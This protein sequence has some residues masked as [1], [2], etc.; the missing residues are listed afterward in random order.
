MTEANRYDIAIIGGGLAG[1]S[2][3][4]ALQ[5][6]GLKMAVIEA[7]SFD[8]KDSPSFDARSVAL[9]YGSKQIFSALGLWPDIQA[10]GVTPIERIHIS[11]R[12]HSGL[13]RLDCRDEKLEALGYVVDIRILGQVL[14]NNMLACREADYLCPA[15]LQSVEFKPD[16]AAVHYEQ[17]GEQKTLQARLAIA[18]D[19]GQSLVRRQSGI[20]T[21]QGQY[22][23]TA[24]IAN[25]LMDKPH[26][27][28][29]YERFTDTGPM[30]L[31]PTTHADHPDCM[32]AL[33]WT[34][35]DDKRDEI[36]SLSDEAFIERL[37]ARFGLRAGRFIKA[38]PRHA[39]PLG[40]MLAREHVR[41]RL[42]VIGNAAHT[43]HPVAGQGFN[44]GLRDVASLAQVILDA[45]RQQQDIGSINVLKGYAKWRRKDHL[46]T[47]GFTDGL[48]RVFSSHFLPVIAARNLGLLALDVLPPVKHAITRH[49][50]GFVGKLSRLAR[51]IPL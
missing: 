23:Q 7:T 10:K 43:M 8:A 28:L 4:A 36:L 9:S 46:L 14:G 19:G 48:V 29:A 42:A 20:R 1:A 47:M 41:P 22:G 32:Y 26:G 6:H 38:G 44:L 18:A 15:R 5:G 31:L 40:V 17:D 24:I 35:A 25:V 21:W 49:A 30:A 50:M 34:V 3:V 2:L 11:D 51:G 45:V 37:Q 33:V 16:H 13:A 39:Y 27:H 12:T